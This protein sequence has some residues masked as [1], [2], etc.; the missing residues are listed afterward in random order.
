MLKKTPSKAA[1]SEEAR[2]TLR[3]V[4]AMQERCMGKGASWRVGVGRVRKN[5]FF[6]ILLEVP[7]LH[8]IFNA[9]DVEPVARRV[10]HTDGILP[11][12]QFLE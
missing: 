10:E 7:R 6:S 9:I 11:F 1:A 8:H 5:G 2:R 4:E 12:Q 3:Y